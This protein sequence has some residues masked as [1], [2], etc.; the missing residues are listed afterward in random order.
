MRKAIELS[1]GHHTRLPGQR[2]DLT[3]MCRMSADRAQVP[4]L[5]IQGLTHK[6]RTASMSG[7]DNSSIWVVATRDLY[8]L[9][10]A[11]DI[12]CAASRLRRTSYY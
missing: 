2:N 3:E 1:T 7:E 6:A 4:G 9:H 10:V 11:R 12:I 5:S 8:V